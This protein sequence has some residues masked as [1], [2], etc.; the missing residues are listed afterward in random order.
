[1]WLTS[2]LLGRHLVALSG[3][4]IRCKEGIVVLPDGAFA[5]ESIYGRSVLRQHREY[6]FRTRRPTVRK[7]G[8]YFS[9]LVNWSADANYYHWFHDTLTRLFGVREHLPPDVRYV[10]PAELTGWQRDSLA[11]LGL[12]E[13]QLD[14]FDGTETWDLETLFFANATTWS[15][16]DRVEVD[17]WLRDSLLHG[18]GVRMG[19]PRRRLYL[20]RRSAPTRLVSNNDAV[21]ELLRD[22]GFECVEPEQLAFRDQVALFTEAEAIVAPH[23]AGLTNMLFAPPG[24]KVADILPSHKLD[25]SYVFCQ[26]AAALQHDYWYFV[27]DSV[28]NPGSREPDMEIS[29][30][31]LG[32]TLHRML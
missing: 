23:G 27:T 5:A 17:M 16:Q 10:V 31:K 21:E 13:A 12:C 24:C 7:R 14:P 32:A 3:A 1:V 18:V 6:Q 19:Q 2:E 26:M 30:D 29:L 22:Y 8:T 11:A 20:T 4:S 9:L 28:E 25:W 15:G